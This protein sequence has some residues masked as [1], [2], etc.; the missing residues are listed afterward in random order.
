MLHELYSEVILAAILLFIDSLQFSLKESKHGV[1]ETFTVQ[2]APLC[3]ILWGT[4]AM[5]YGLVKGGIGV[6]S[7]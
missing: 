7:S 1:D 3:Y 2:L 5:I 6:D 4:L